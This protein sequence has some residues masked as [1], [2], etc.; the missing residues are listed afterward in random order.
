M[1]DITY[2][3]A[4][5]DNRLQSDIVSRKSAFNGNLKCSGFD[6]LITLNFAYFLSLQWLI[7]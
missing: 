4:D 1:T 7:S 2:L 3:T 6:L 5:K